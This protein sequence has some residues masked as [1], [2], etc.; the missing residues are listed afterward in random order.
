MGG[1][2]S[3]LMLKQYLRWLPAQI[4]VFN[5]GAFNLQID[6]I[7]E[8]DIFIVS[9]PK[10]GNTWVRFLLANMK[11]RGEEINF[12]NIEH[13]IPDVYTSKTL[14]NKQKKNR[15]IK[16]H[17]NLLE[18]YPKSIYIYRDYRDVLVSYY[19]YEKALGNFSGSISEFI[20]S[21][22]LKEPFGLWKDHVS[23]AIKFKEKNPKRILMLSYESLYQNGLQQAKLLAD[24]CNL[25]PELPFEE[26]LNRCEFSNLKK[27]EKVYESEFKKRSSKHFFREGKIENWNVYLNNSDLEALK[28]D[29]ELVLLMKK[30]N[31]NF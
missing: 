25:T 14:I 15:I 11:S 22:N 20:T 24:F 18:Y 29:T 10:S 17:N 16:T 4:G 6:K 8:D 5:K 23:K 26:I 27:N 12:N 3:F 19:F 7:L 30:L 31:Y 13:Y 9:Y 1:T 21:K 2:D 28:K